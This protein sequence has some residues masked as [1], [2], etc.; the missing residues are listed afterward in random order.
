MLIGDAST[1]YSEFYLVCVNKDTLDMA[2]RRVYS[3]FSLL[4][5]YCVLF[6]S[7]LSLLF[8]HT[9]SH[10]IARMS[11]RSSADESA[12]LSE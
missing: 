11:P 1:I 3:R 8:L 10:V 5:W 6:S 9:F 7:T 12:V 4:S 2:V